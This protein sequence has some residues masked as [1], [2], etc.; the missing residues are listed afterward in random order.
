MPETVQRIVEKNP[1]AP[2]LNK[3][4]VDVSILFLDVADYTRISE[5]LTQDKVNFIIEKSFLASWT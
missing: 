5:S 1:D 2:E 4:E 3:Q